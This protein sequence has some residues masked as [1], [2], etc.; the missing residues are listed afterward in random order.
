MSLTTPSFH[1]GVDLGGTNMSAAIVDSNNRAIRAVRR[2]TRAHL[3]HESVLERIG[4]MVTLVRKKAGLKRQQ[5]GGLGIGVPAAIDIASGIAL[6]APNLGWKHLEIRT[7]MEK[8]TGLPTAID[9]DVNVA[10]YG[11]VKAGAAVGFE[12]AL[13]I[14]TGTGVGGGLVLSGRLYY[15]HHFTAGEIGHAVVLPGSGLGRET[16]E[17]VASRGAIVRTLRELIQSGHA[18]IIGEMVEGDFAQ[19][20]SKVLARAVLAGDK[21]ALRVVRDAARLTGIVAANFVTTLSLPCVVLG[22]GLPTELGAAWGDWVRESAVKHV[23]P[24]KLRS[25]VV[26]VTQLG[27]ESGTIGAAIVAKE[28]L[29]PV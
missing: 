25:V 3:G 13:G 18:S 12:D 2:K 6:D 28:R 14:W 17:E 1:I 8:I 10:L 5:I 16:L 20:K 23:W 26:V 27:D 15:G 7:L 21:L 9:N 11:E 29:A 4:E 24:E 22:G 19:I